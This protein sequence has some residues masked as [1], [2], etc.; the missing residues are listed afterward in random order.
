MIN[1][2]IFLFVLMLPF[3]LS[4]QTRKAIPAG[5]Y[6]SLSGIK[7]ARAKSE[8]IN[9]S[10]NQLSIWQELQ[11]NLASNRE[12][13]YYLKKSSS[14]LSLTSYI[15][16]K[17]FR[18]GRKIDGSF[19]LLVT[20]NLKRDREDLKQLANDGVVLFISGS[21]LTDN[22]NQINGYNLILFQTNKSENYY[23]LKLK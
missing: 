16:S 14:N 20:D 17:N 1:V 3:A 9:N 6:E 15:P 10:S 2:G 7:L 11:K 21:T 8:T 5:R 23:L 18:E 4:S 19:D 12:E 13:F 22:M